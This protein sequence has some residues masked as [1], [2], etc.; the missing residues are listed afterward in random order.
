MNKDKK[1]EDVLAD[2]ARLRVPLQFMDSWHRPGYRQMTDGAKRVSGVAALRDASYR[3]Y[4]NWATNAWRGH[5]EY[6][7][8]IGANASDDPTTG[9]GSRGPR[10][11]KEGDPCTRN[12]WP[13][14]LVRGPDGQ[15]FCQINRPDGGRDADFPKRKLKRGKYGQEEGEEEFE[16][17]GLCP[18]CN[19][20]GIAP[21]HRQTDCADGRGPGWSNEPSEH[22]EALVEQAVRRATTHH[23]SNLRTD[24][25]GAKTLDGLR[26]RHAANMQKIYADSDCE[27]SEQWRKK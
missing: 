3:D 10:G 13:G 27:L 11:S 16:E 19:G 14:N 7:S 5:D 17:D 22:L 2:G 9:F 26:A 24:V 4:Q 1:D 6:A 25:P 21:G 20:S 8:P 12:G 15:L 18:T 23:E